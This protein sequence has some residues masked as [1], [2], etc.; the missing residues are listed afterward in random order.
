L[1]AGVFLSAY[2]QPKDL[3]AA[4]EWLSR[5]NAVI[6][7]GCTDLLALTPNHSLSGDVLDISAIDAL[8]GVERQADG[9]R[10]GAG[11]TWADLAATDLPVCFA[12]LQQA[13]L[14]VGSCQIQAVATVGGNLCNA[15]PAA[16]GVVPL[17]TLG[18][19][20]ELASVRGRRRMGVAQFITGPRQTCLAA[21]EL[22]VA[23][24]IPKLQARGGSAFVKLGARK[25][26]VISI[27]MAAARVELEVG[28]ISDIAV[29]VGACG[30][31]ATRLPEV[32]QALLGGAPAA[33][34][35][36][37]TDELVNARISPIDD[38]RADQ[39]YRITAAGE[40]V[41]RAI[42]QAVEAAQ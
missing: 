15:S 33:A 25:Y 39:S 36:Q 16:D 27:A 14:Q 24:Y 4:L 5:N 37:V 26:L 34:I 28:K 41:R 30:P 22:L 17:L 3:P 42:T 11:V 13:A 12:G 32:E 18:A 8:G 21:D 10:I 38:I 40:V 29:S 1:I 2:F 19:E 20:V 7:A 35:G 23:L 9:W 6:A 31:V